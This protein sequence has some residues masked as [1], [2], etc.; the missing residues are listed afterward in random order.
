[1]NTLV[2]HRH[3]SD[4]IKYPLR[5]KP[6][7]VKVNQKDLINCRISEPIRFVNRSSYQPLSTKPL[8][9]YKR[10]S[11]LRGLVKEEPFT[12]GVIGKYI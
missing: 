7:C 4:L 8:L 6:K 9:T 11:Y 3:S 2:T 1:M 10:R 5:S 12:A